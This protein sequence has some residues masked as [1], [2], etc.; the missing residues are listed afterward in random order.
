[1]RGKPYFFKINKYSFLGA[2]TSYGA[3]VPSVCSVNDL[4]FIECTYI[5]NI[6]SSIFASNHERHWPI[7]ERSQGKEDCYVMA[8]EHVFVY[9]KEGGEGRRSTSHPIDNPKTNT[10]YHRNTFEAPQMFDYGT[11]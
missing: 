9:I 2:R 11:H 5:P 1:M 10:M 8:Y 6:D 7:I 3:T 4:L